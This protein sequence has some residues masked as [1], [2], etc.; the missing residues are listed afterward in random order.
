MMDKLEKIFDN[1]IS[2]LGEKEQI[3]FR[4]FK[5]NAFNIYNNILKP[6]L[7]AIFLFWLFA[8]IKNTIG[9]QEAFYV[10]GVVIIIFLRLIASRL[11]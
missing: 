8:R 10:Q 5:N 2:Q 3:F 1:Q 6:V 11:A 7:W 4:K 9:I